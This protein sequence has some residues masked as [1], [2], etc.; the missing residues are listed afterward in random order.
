MINIKNKTTILYNSYDTS[1]YFKK[2]YFS[3]LS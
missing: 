1:N 3:D 2:S